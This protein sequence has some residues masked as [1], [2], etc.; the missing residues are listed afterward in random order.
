MSGWYVLHASMLTVWFIGECVSQCTVHK[1]LIR[2]LTF[3]NHHY[4]QHHHHLA[5]IQFAK[6]LTRSGLT[7]LELSIIVSLGFFCPL[8]CSFLVSPV[9]YHGAHSLCVATNFLCIP[10]FCPKLGLYYFL[11]NLFVSQTVLFLLTYFIN[12]A[13]I[14]LESPVTF[15]GKENLEFIKEIK[16]NTAHSALADSTTR[17][18]AVPA[19]PTALKFK[20][21]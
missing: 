14:L 9:I 4:H 7:R 10:V 17:N 3:T 18:T 20:W 13:V 16:H 11:C 21:C 19:A 6:L 5:K 15:T 12:A 1:T 8:V 2:H